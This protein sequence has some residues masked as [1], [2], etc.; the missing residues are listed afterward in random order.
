[1][2]KIAKDIC[3]NQTLTK[4]E[5]RRAYIICIIIEILT[6]WLICW[7]MDNIFWLL[8]CIAF[9]ALLDIYILYDRIKRPPEIKEFYII[10]DVFLNAQESNVLQNR[11]NAFSYGMRYNYK[12]KFSQN[13]THEAMFFSK[14]EPKEIDADYSAVFF[15]QPGD[16]FYLL[17]SSV[18]NKQSI[19][20]VFNAK[21]YE[22]DENDF[23]YKDGKY[24]PKK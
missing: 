9:F 11:I 1:M 16:K 24:Y 3:M 22:L 5:F 19:I 21:Y 4:Q 15:S 6:T 18:Q 7:C 8:F 14:K 23:D 20:K 10:E 12:I 13:G 17:M 2:K